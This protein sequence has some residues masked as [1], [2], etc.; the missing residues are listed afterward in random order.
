MRRLDGMPQCIQALQ[1]GE[2]DVKR[3]AV[4]GHD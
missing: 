1:Q 3:Q 2:G 4:Q